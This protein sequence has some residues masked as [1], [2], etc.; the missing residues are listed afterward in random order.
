MNIT[1]ILCTYNRC[2]R[3]AK[4]LESVAVSVLPAG[5]EWE[6]LVV[7][8][9]SNDETRLVVESFSA[10]FP[11]RFRYFFEQRQGKSFALN[12][13]ILGAKGGLLAFMDD[14]VV[15][16]P[17]WLRNVT[18]PLESSEWAGVGGRIRLQETF[19]APPWL[20]L[21]GPN[22]LAGMLAQFDLGDRACG[23][24][25]PPFGTNM[26][27]PKAIFKEYGSFRTD[28]GPSPGSEI[29]N[30]DTEFARRLFLGGEKLWYEPSA[31]VYH[32]VPESRL[33]KD[34][35]LKFWYDHGRALVREKEQ[36]PSVFGIPRD[37]FAISKAAAIMLPMRAI[38]WFLTF[39][40]KGRFFA[41]GMVWS[42]LGQIAETCN[43]WKGRKKSIVGGSTDQ[44]GIARQP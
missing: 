20:P 12:S 15:V 14:D 5:A 9:N 38:R 25:V 17:T 32:E 26:A 22:T 19:T 39:D 10:R 31:I 3:L 23:L 7:D 40:A 21:D 34:Y 13:A 42:T 8:N 18:A 4:A 28:M 30:E 16:D 1:V 27:F 11:G 35:F 43:S 44:T 37:C 29:R 2:E 6:V 36:K 33:N 24:T 41:K